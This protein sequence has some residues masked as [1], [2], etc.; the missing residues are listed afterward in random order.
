[1]Q[2]NKLREKLNGRYS[3]LLFWMQS[4]DGIDLMTANPDAAISKL[5]KLEKIVPEA[6]ILQMQTNDKIQQQLFAQ[7]D[8]YFIN[9]NNA[10]LLHEGMGKSAF[11]EALDKLP[12]DETHN[13]AVISGNET[14]L[15]WLK[16]KLPDLKKAGIE[17]VPP[18]ETTF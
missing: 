11:L 16:D 18:P 13:M 4:K 2:A 14:T 3:R 5:K 12:A 17:I 9:T 7:T 8:L 10:L 1:M 15:S 6:R